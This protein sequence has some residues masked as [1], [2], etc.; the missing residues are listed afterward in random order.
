MLLLVVRGLC[1]PRS[2]DRLLFHLNLCR[3]WQSA[4]I[5]KNR[6]AGR[7][8]TGRRFEMF[9]CLFTWYSSYSWPE[10]SCGGARL[11][12]SGRCGLN[13]SDSKTAWRRPPVGRHAFNC[14]GQKESG[15]LDFSKPPPVNDKLRVEMGLPSSG[16]FLFCR[17]A[18][19]CLFNICF[20][21]YSSY[22]RKNTIPIKADIMTIA[23]DVKT[24]EV[25]KGVVMAVLQ[26]IEDIP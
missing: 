20:V 2:V 4:K 16:F 12:L 3:K 5:D 18:D 13:H 6:P 11:F 17:W 25:I 15:G 7:K 14:W 8:P 22:L 10:F 24:M 9:C 23:N 1:W 19:G 21:C 26:R